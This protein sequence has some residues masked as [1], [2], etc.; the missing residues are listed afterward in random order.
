M[1]PSF[2][3]TFYDDIENHVQ[4]GD[5]TYIDAIV[6]WCESRRVDIDTIVPMI[7]RNANLQLKLQREGE[8]LNI[9]KRVV[10]LPI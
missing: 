9:L 3:S 2:D 6:H 5:V 10:R 1:I 8:N 7:V 4:N